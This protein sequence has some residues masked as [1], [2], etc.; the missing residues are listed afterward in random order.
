MARLK[1]P[2]TDAIFHCKLE[3]VIAGTEI[4]WDQKG[5]LK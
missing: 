3:R 1:K 4:A 5:W 2:K